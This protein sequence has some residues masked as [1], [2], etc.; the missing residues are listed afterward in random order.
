MKLGGR[1]YH[2]KPSLTRVNINFT[3]LSADLENLEKP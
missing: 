2:K 1:G 3:G